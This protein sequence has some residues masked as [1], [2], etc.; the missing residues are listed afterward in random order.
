MAN[1]SDWVA[2][3]IAT[4]VMCFSVFNSIAGECR[5]ESR[6]HRVT[7]IELYT[8]EGCNSCPP[9]DRWFGG[10]PQQGISPETA[11]L[12]AF[13][14]DYWN[15]L[16]WPDRFSRPQF[17]DRQRDVTARHGS[18]VIYTPQLTVDGRDFRQRYDLESL[19]SKLTAIKRRA[20]TPARGSTMTT[21]YGSLRVHSRSAQGVAL[22]WIIG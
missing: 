15:Q 21:L 22:H 16:G 17:S 2:P 7:V 13:H 19:G 4:V 9:V 3:A 12:L 5:L 8:S 20:R 1:K 18:G 10:L 6:A 14:V 11:V